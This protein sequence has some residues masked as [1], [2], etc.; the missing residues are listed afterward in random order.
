MCYLL[1]VFGDLAAGNWESGDCLLVLEQ[2][3]A[4]GQLFSV[5]CLQNTIFLAHAQGISQREERD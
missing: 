4:G 1:S 2:P 5:I 3:G